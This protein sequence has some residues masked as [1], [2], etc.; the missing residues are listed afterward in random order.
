MEFRVSSVEW[1][2]VQTFLSVSQQ[3]L[4]DLLI[5]AQELGANLGA[6]KRVMKKNKKGVLQN[7]DSAKTPLNNIKTLNLNS[8]FI[9]CGASDLKI[10]R[11]EQVLYR[12]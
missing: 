9:S 6:F 5:E 4:A 8:D 3:S 1:D 12:L 11:Q 2:I 7:S 10:K